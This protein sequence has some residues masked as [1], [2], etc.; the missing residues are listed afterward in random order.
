M[1]TIFAVFPTDGV[2]TRESDRSNKYDSGPE[3]DSDNFFTRILG[4]PSESMLK[5]G[6]RWFKT[7]RTVNT[8]NIMLLSSL[9]VIEAKCGVSSLSIEYTEAKH[10]LKTCAMEKGSIGCSLLSLRMQLSLDFENN[11][12]N[13]NYNKIMIKIIIIVIAIILIIMGI[14]IIIVIIIILIIKILI[15]IV[16]L[17][18]IILIFIIKMIIFITIIAIVMQSKL[19]V[20]FSE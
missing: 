6:L 2:N 1:G 3:S 5:V 18:I 10:L 12:D 17:I 16:I 11:N 14:L 8:E 13:D 19:S 15:L 9:L 4:I 7:F 20:K